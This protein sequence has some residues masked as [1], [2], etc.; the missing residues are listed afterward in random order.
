M[1][2]PVFMHYSCSMCDN[3]DLL[4]YLLNGLL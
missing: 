4:T 2:V 1:F 3:E